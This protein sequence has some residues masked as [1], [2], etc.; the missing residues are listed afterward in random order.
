MRF[1]MAVTGGG[2]GAISALLGVTGASRSILAATVPYADEAL[3][4]WLG[5]KPDEFCA[6]ATARAMAM[7]AFLKARQYDPRA[8]TC[9]VACTASLRSDR[10][11]RGA[12]RAH[13]AYQTASTTGTLSLELEKGRRSRAEEEALVMSLVL[14]LVAEACG[15]PGRLS[16]PLA[17]SEQI[18]T[19]RIVAPPDQQDLLAG[20]TQAIRLKGTDSAR[21][22]ALFPGAF[23]PL[24]AGHQQMAEVARQIL[25]H[26]LAYEIS[27]LNVDKPPL[28]FLE[29]DQR[30]RQFSAL[31]EVWLTRAPHFTEKAA[32]FP[33]ATFVVG[34]DTIA[35]VGHPRYYGG[36]EA[37][38]Q[39]ALEQIAAAGC[40]FLVFGRVVDG[41]F[42]TLSKLQLPPTLAALCQEVPEGSFRQDIAATELRRQARG[43]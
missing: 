14:N 20:R 11:K 10:P 13:L 43:E 29:I 32:L 2:S 18:A 37:A 4:E 3:V 19:Q 16:V 22:P 36:Q 26:D 39:A 38:M 6:P 5:G 1:V 35:R 17:K 21:P 7:A 33:G 30:T 8:E 28:D 12:H 40:R 15:A 25:G 41:T 42:R 27:I 31:Q 9:G 34:A 23:H 24:H